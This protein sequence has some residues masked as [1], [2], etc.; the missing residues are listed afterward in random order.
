MRMSMDAINR[1]SGSVWEFSDEWFEGQKVTSNGFDANDPHLIKVLSLT[2]QFV[3]F[4]RQLGE[5]T[6]G[7]VITQGKLIRPVSCAQC[8]DGRQDK[9]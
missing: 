8:K 5:H 7:F 3:G 9:H 1:L 4:P 6:G 2:R